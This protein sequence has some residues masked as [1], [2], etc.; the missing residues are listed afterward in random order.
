M[1]LAEGSHRVSK[2]W[3]VSRGK[4]IPLEEME[5]EVS[6]TESGGLSVFA[7]VHMRVKVPG[8]SPGESDIEIVFEWERETHRIAEAKVFDVDLH[9]N[10][11]TT[12]QLTGRLERAEGEISP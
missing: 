12:L 7:N 4:R 6:S 11:E 3:L 9:P 5:I 2:A 8:L 10:G 1:S